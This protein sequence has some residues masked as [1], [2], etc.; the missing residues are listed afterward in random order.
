MSEKYPVEP[1]YD[2][3]A[4]RQ[5]ESGIEG[6][7]VVIEGYQPT[8]SKSKPRHYYN[9]GI[10]KEIK[11]VKYI[12]EETAKIAWELQQ[13]EWEEY[14]NKSIQK[15][16]EAALKVLERLAK[17]AKLHILSTNHYWGEESL[18]AGKRY[19]MVK[20]NEIDYEIGKLREKWGQE[21]KKG[22]RDDL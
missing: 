17:N 15:T 19:P 18:E 7:E 5:E 20:K 22:G 8:S 4:L 11:G 12:P 16:K 21:A 9:K 3:E 2:L 14:C 13:S 10:V 1:D 6:R